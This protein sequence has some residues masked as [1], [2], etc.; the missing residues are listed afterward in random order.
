M[1]VDFI[2]HKLAYTMCM[3]FLKLTFAYL[4]LS[5]L[6]HIVYVDDFRFMSNSRLYMCFHANDDVI[7]IR[8]KPIYSPTRK[9][10]LRIKLTTAQSGRTTSARLDA[11]NSIRCFSF[12]PDRALVTR[13]WFGDH[14]R[15]GG[16]VRTNRAA[17]CQASTET[18]DPARS[19]GTA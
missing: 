9:T 15:S 10:R 3:I 5:F 1:Q 8:L 13:S 16:P 14:S 19:S 7:Q 6:V 11:R 4:K 17:Y 18:F 12:G 2:Y